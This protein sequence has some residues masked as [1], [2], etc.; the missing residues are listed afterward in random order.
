MVGG[1]LVA[2]G[3]SATARFGLAKGSPDEIVIFGSRLAQPIDITDRATL[4]RFS[5]SIGEFIDW[6]RGAFA[7][8]PSCGDAYDVRFYQRWEGRQS[9]FDRGPLKL[10]FEFT[11]CP[12]ARG[13]GH[14][15]LP[16]P[17]E[18]FYDYN[19]GTIARPGKDG[20]WFRATVQ[21]D[22]VLVL[23]KGS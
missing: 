15:K 17:G 4:R 10:I 11:Y 23:S 12:S 1:I 8:R 7:A 18:Q 22:S 16:G 14:V 20:H 19:T 3:I 5:P 21:W 13:P 6:D 9:K 2:I